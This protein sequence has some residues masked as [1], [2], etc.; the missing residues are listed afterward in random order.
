AM[1]PAFRRARQLHQRRRLC[2][3]NLQRVEKMSEG[4][5]DLNADLVRSLPDTGPVVMINYLRFRERSLDGQ[6]SGWDAYVRYS[7]GFA[8]LL[9]RVGGSILWTGKVEGA[10]YGDPGERW[11]FVALVHYPSRAAFLE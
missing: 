4:P 5:S 1:D 3:R 8:P 2:D 11:D 9:K 6:G 10:A 7:K